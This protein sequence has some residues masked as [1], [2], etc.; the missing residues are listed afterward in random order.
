MID[1][2]AGTLVVHA[3]DASVSGK[4]W[5]FLGD[6]FRDPRVSELPMLWNVWVS[7]DPLADGQGCASLDA[8]DIGNVSWNGCGRH[9]RLIPAGV[10]QGT[11]VLDLGAAVVAQLIALDLAVA[12]S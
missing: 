8:Q 2:F 10:R 5:N 3:S 11:P 9:P 7:D 4:R 6:P 1:N 12:D